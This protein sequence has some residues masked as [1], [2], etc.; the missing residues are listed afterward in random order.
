[1]SR[2]LHY[3]CSAGISGDMNLAALIDLGVPPS[4][5]EE[6][7][8]LLDLPGFHIVV[9]KAEKSGL[10]GTKVTV[11]DNPAHEGQGHKH[12]H[13]HE[14]AH[15]HSHD[16][17]GHAHEHL[18]EHGTTE[19]A[20]EH[21]H[22]THEV[23]EAHDHGHHHHEHRS[24]ADIRTLIER[25]RLPESVKQRATGIFA[26][27]AEAEGQV[28]GKTP[29]EVHFHEVGA[30]DSLIDIVGAAICLDYLK[31]DRI[32]STSVELGSGTVRCAHGVLPVPAPATLL[33]MKGLPSS[34]G[35]TDHEA[36]TPTGAAIMKTVVDEFNPTLSGTCVATGLGIGHRDSSRRPNVLRASLWDTEETS[37]VSVESMI[38]LSANIDDMTA[39]HLAH[40]T[41]CL[42][43]AG[44][45]DAWQ[46][47][48]YMKKG[49]L[50]TKVCALVSSGNKAAVLNA[51]F[52]HTSTLGIREQEIRRHALARG[53]YTRETPWGQVRIKTVEGEFRREKV[54]YEDVSRIA[55]EN[56]LTIREVTEGCR[57]ENRN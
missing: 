41:G 24:F 21:G 38:E 36:T 23:H 20:H 35:G 4:W 17:S 11:H 29:D 39:E 26:V 53:E 18:H 22:H 54:E 5:V 52:R 15:P 14:H 25:S 33:L 19:H 27:L 56:H 51:F 34:I 13:A 45:V 32:T 3:D 30:V 49:R 8:A 9:E 6:Q 42:F 40:L 44:A 28:H 47:A 57:E 1:M 31:P 16:H 12:E 46:E 48:V 2:V 50:G 55:R 37:A 43:E 10:W 7:C